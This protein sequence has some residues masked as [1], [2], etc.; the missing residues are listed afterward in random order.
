MLLDS[1]KRRV[2]LLCIV[3][4]SAIWLGALALSYVDARKEVNQL[5]DAHLAQAASLLAA[6]SAAEAAEIDTEHAPDLHKYARSVSFQIWRGGKTLGLHSANAPALAL[7]AHAEGFSEREVDGVRWRVFTSWDRERENLIQVGE[8][9]ALRDHLLKEMLEH[10]LQPMLYALPLLALLL[11]LAVH[12]GLRP[13]D[14][15]ATE[16][17]RRH[18]QRLDAV[19][20]QGAP[21]EVRP[22]IGQLNQLLLR[23]AESLDNTRRF[24][25]DA[26]HEL[27]T[28][29]AAIRAQAQVAQSR[30]DRDE[31]ARALQQ[32]LRGCDLATHLIEQLLTLA[33]LDAAGLPARAPVDLRALLADLLAEMAG[34][35]IEAQVEVALEDGPSI[36]VPVQPGL[37]RILLRNLIDNAIR[38]SP[39][40]SEVC[41]TIRDCGDQAAID[42]VDG[43]PGIPAAELERVFD[44][45]YRVLGS[46]QAGSGL[47]LSIARRIAEIHGGQLVLAPR[48]GAAGLIASVRLPL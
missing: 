19:D 32:V 1:L 21:A 45:F 6:Q 23:V 39:A 4:L 35:A 2:V 28:P 38:Y 37:L 33:R 48:E 3:A 31:Q 13:L 20:I 34:S 10:L 5:L 42:V 8:Q 29:L 27:R 26:A 36:Q 14:R 46:A 40:G 11:W 18:P 30:H 47:G 7:G 44:R 12:L 17:A 22:L 24:T 25:A 15:V 16:I 43:G 9:I 41:V